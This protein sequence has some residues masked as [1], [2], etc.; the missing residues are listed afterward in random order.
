M[1]AKLVEA[2]PLASGPANPQW[3]APEGESDP[4]GIELVRGVHGPADDGWTVVVDGLHVGLNAT[5]YTFVQLPPPVAVDKQVTRET[6]VRPVVVAMRLEDEARRP[7]RV[8]L[9]LEQVCTS[10]ERANYGQEDE[11][12]EMARMDIAGY[13]PCD[14]FAPA[15]SM[16]Y[17][18]RAPAQ[19]A[20]S[21]ISYK[22]IE[23]WEKDLE[24]A[25]VHNAGVRARYA[26]KTAA[27]QA[28]KKYNEQVEA[29]WSVKEKGWSARKTLWNNSPAAIRGAPPPRPTKSGTWKLGK[30]G[31]VMG[32]E[33]GLAEKPTDKESSYIIGGGNTSAPRAMVDLFEDLTKACETTRSSA[34]NSKLELLTEDG[35]KVLN[36]GASL[37]VHLDAMRALLYD[38]D[39]ST[40]KVFLEALLGSA[41]LPMT[42]VLALSPAPTTE[43]EKE[44][45]FA[46]KNYTVTCRDDTQA[47]AQR[48]A[49]DEAR[50]EI[51]QKLAAAQQ[52]LAAA[53][54]EAEKVAP[55]LE[56]GSLEALLEAGEDRYKVLRREKPSNA[57]D[58]REALTKLVENDY[59]KIEQQR[60]S[61]TPSD[62]SYEFLYERLQLEALARTSV[63]MRLRIEVTNTAGVE[64]VNVQFDAPEIEGLV[65]H[66][67]YAGLYQDVY[68]LDQ[69]GRA[70]V[71][72]MFEMY[73][74]RSTSSKLKDAASSAA[75][76]VS[77]VASKIVPIA[78]P[79]KSNSW[80]VTRWLN[81]KKL[82]YGP[83]F[84]FD[85]CELEIMV[86]EQMVQA[87]MLLPQWPQPNPDSSPTIGTGD[88][89]AAGPPPVATPIAQGTSSDEVR[90]DIP[91]LHPY[92]R[93]VPISDEDD[94]LLTILP[95]LDDE[96]VDE[97]LALRLPDVS[98][99]RAAR[100]AERAYQKGL[101]T[102]LEESNNQ[103]SAWLD[104]DDAYASAVAKSNLVTDARLV[105]YDPGTNILHRV[106]AQ[107]VR[108]TYRVSITFQAMADISPPDEYYTT[109]RKNKWLTG[110]IG[111]SIFLA[112]YA[113]F[114]YAT[115][116][117]ILYVLSYIRDIGFAAQEVGMMGRLAMGMADMFNRA[118]E[119]KDWFSAF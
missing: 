82:V 60:G 15:A 24:L 8:Q 50:K 99:E 118:A 100:I 97:V 23:K 95:A 9:I 98:G 27:H 106:M 83:A 41:P 107:V 39:K 58:E 7:D 10:D 64:P 44:T 20:V 51:K 85:P 79:N 114:A 56:V 62:A 87:R 70:F 45:N 89:A 112:I 116:A 108:P 49:S 61:G 30:S 4:I 14:P 84:H 77:D 117:G 115:Y 105:R 102:M 86:I 6:V 31:P 32:A 13:R 2:K 21:I 53:V 18:F 48:K 43:D 72:C 22:H 109:P 75:R 38:Q 28:R 25:S 16:P 37:R 91:G 33:R 76:A 111:A 63:R 69:K 59:K 88:V 101:Q 26:A 46:R 3:P 34:T 104:E 81:L 94:A 36:K 17:P 92:R 47:Q 80:W 67:I 110:L 1:A 103:G 71:D 93:T 12:I 65:A 66:A 73:A 74:E 78:N 29:D 19:S 40:A 42:R 119:A 5:G 90:I 96:I 54:T 113:G 57:Q 52:K 11:V 68:D 55:Q 35:T